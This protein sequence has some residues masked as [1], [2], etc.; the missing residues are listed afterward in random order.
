MPMTVNDLEMFHDAQLHYVR[1][2]LTPD[3][4]DRHL[5]ISD[6]TNDYVNSLLELANDL[7][8]ALYHCQFDSVLDDNDFVPDDV[9]PFDPDATDADDDENYIFNKYACDAVAPMIALAFNIID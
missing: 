4:I 2:Y 5:K 3:T 9:M 6:D 8:V 7:R 1:E